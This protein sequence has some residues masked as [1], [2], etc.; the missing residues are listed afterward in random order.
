MSPRFE[1]H[2]LGFS[3]L[4]DAS[5]KGARA[6]HAVVSDG[7][8]W[9][10]DPI[11]VEGLDARIAA[12][13]EPVAVLQLLDR[14]NR[15]CGPIAERLGVP[16]QKVPFDG[17]PGSPF[18]VVEV[19]NNGRWKEVALWWPQ[20]RALIVPESVGVTDYFRGGGEA[21]G[22]HPLMRFKPPKQQLGG[23][24]PEHLLTGHGTGMHGPGTAAALR[25]SLEHARRRIPS[26]IV[27]LFR[28]G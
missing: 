25:D 26:A 3:W 8:V 18:E 15:D 9:I 11:D 28:S 21:V 16:L 4:A 23:F 6:C 19:V 12:L 24:E 27:S 14:H 22:T 17:V 5:E 7:R 20:R 13:G 1:E 2:D 10:I